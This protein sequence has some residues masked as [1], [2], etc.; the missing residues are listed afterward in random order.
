MEK[1]ELSLLPDDKTTVDEIKAKSQECKESFESY[2]KA[3]STLQTRFKDEVKVLLPSDIYS[4]DLAQ[5]FDIMKPLHE[6]KK[7]FSDIN[8]KI[9]KTRVILK[10]SQDDLELI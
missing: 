1:F 2:L 6:M 4:L 5:T 7:E 9:E 10:D 8:D 3:H